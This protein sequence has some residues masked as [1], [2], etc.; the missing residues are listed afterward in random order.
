MANNELNR[1][2]ALFLIAYSQQELSAVSFRLFS[3]N[4]PKKW[5]YEQEVSST[6]VTNEDLE[7]AWSDEYGAKYSEDR[8]RLLK[9]EEYKL[10]FYKIKNG[11]KVICNEAFYDWI[12][13]VS[14]IHLLKVYIPDCVT[15]IGDLAFAYCDYLQEI[16]IPDS[17][18][19]IGI[20]PFAGCQL[21]IN[22]LTKNF[23]VENN[24]LYSKDKKRLI[25]FCSKETNFIVP[26]SVTI[27]GDN[28]FSGCKLLQSVYI[29]DSVTSIGNNA[30]SWCESMDSV[31]IPNSVT[32]IGENAFLQCKSIQSVFIPDS[33]T[34]IGKNAFYMCESLNEIIVPQ[35]MMPKFEKLLPNDLYQYLREGFPPIL[36]LDILW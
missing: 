27:V 12:K 23:I 29:P 34:S 10:T 36:M 2:Y 14:Q 24:V 20:N 32:I 1:L 4:K 31:T 21:N 5:V 7:K 33:V 35:G 18:N 26:D 19:F 9:V 17:V 3:L 13:P 16:S 8:K 22:C 11:T 30:F 25:S 28:A 15:V 6:K